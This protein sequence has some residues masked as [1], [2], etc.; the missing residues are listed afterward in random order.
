MSDDDAS[1]AGIP[2]P[3]VRDAIDAV[4]EGVRRQADKLRDAYER[5][6]RR[7]QLRLAFVVFVAAYLVFRR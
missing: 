2:I 7:A 3:P 1:S 4:K 6:R 5:A